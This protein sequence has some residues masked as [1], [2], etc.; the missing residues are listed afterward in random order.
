MSSFTGRMKEYPTVSLDRFDRENL[1]ARAYFLS[2]CHKGELAS[3]I[4][5][6][7]AFLKFRKDSEARRSRKSLI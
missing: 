7:V 6:A 1:H 4:T 2:H 5:D 3:G